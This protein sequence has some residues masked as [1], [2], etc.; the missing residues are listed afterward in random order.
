MAKLPNPNA[1]GLTK[2]HIDAMDGLSDIA[3]GRGNRSERLRFVEEAMENTAVLN[4]PTYK[5]LF[6]KQNNVAEALAGGIH[7]EMGT[8]DIHGIPEE[9]GK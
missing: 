5:E 2:N 7:E 1:C 4:M 3:L 8:Q 9:H 6:D